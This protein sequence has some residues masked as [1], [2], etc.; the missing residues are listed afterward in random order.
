[1]LLEEFDVDKFVRTIRQEGIQIGLRQGIQQG[2]EQGIK[3][4]TEQGIDCVNRLTR[5]LL[6]QGRIEDLQ[7]S[8]EDAE[9]Q[10]TL[11]HE[12]DL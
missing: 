9:Y 3:Q 6:E 4:G 2:T 1:M 12:F 11:F 10:R 8:S 5:L 7:R